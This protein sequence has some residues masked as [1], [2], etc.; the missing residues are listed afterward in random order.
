MPSSLTGT[1]L[2]PAR[3]FNVLTLTTVG[4]LVLSPSPSLAEYEEQLINDDVSGEESRI[5]PV[6]VRLDSGDFIAFWSDNSRGHT[7]VLSRRFDTSLSPLDEPTRV[8]SDEGLFSH[9][10]VAVSR[11][12]GGLFLAVWEDARTGETDRSI[13]G[14]IFDSDSGEPRTSDFRIDGTLG[15]GTDQRPR[16]HTSPD[17]ESLVVWVGLVNQKF[18]V[19]ARRIS[20][21]GSLGPDVIAAPENPTA[22]QY[23]PAVS[24]TPDGRWLLVWTEEDASH[25]RNIFF[26]FLAADGSTLGTPVRVNSDLVFQAYQDDPDVALIGSRFLLVWND[27]R[28]GP[29]D[30]WGRWV[31]F[32]GSFDGLDA[33][34]RPNQD[35]ASDQRPRIHP[36]PGGSFSISWFGGIE[37]RQRAMAQYYDS[38]GQ[39]QVEARIIDDPVSGILQRQPFVVSAGD[40]TWREFWCDNREDFW[41]CFAKPFDPASG[42]AGDRVP[43]RTN[44]RSASQMFADLDIFPDGGA[45]VAWADFRDGSV[46]I[47]A[48]FLDELGSPDGDS[49]RVGSIPANADLTT[50]DAYRSVEDYSPRVAAGANG[51]VVTWAI[52]QLGGR[53][54]FLAQYF[55]RNG[56][57]IGENFLVAP[58]DE[59]RAQRDASPVM[60]P[61]GGFAIAYQ[62]AGGPSDEG[63]SEIYLQRFAS[64]GLPIPPRIIVP[65]GAPRATKVSPSIAVAPSGTIY[66]S[67]IDDR[68]GGL[69]VM[70]QR[71][72]E[73]GQRFDTNVSQNPPDGPSS[74]Q[75][76]TD[77]AIGYDRTVSVW[78]TRPQTLGAI[79]GRLEIFATQPAAGGGEPVSSAKTGG[80]IVLLFQVN[81]GRESRGTKAPRV[82]MAQDGR[83]VVTWWENADGQTQLFAQRYEANGTKI[84]DAYPIHG[85]GSEGSRLPAQLSVDN[86]RIH[87]VWSESRREKGWDIRSRLVD[88]SFSG[89]PTPVLLR[90]AEANAELAGVELLWETALE[91]G[92]RGFH[93]HRQLSD[94]EPSRGLHP[95]AV[96]LTLDPLEAR[97]D[98]TYRYLDRS[99]PPSSRLEYFLQAIDENGQ[100][101]LFG[102]IPVATLAGTSASA[103]PNPFRDTVNLAH[104]TGDPIDIDL[105]DASGRL[106][107]TLPPSAGDDPLIWDGRDE[108]DHEV[109]TGIYFAR[110]RGGTREPIR[111]IRLK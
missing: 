36:G 5:D 49:F 3:L 72:S 109:P 106:I 58:N 37:D 76:N 64:D 108:D 51:F 18:R 59:E 61:H 8:N 52:N 97:A 23:N 54:N 105:Y 84:G 88:W 60:L 20:P 55:D 68:F 107:R 110:P 39:L 95:G 100:T 101:E 65:E 21:T 103:W 102:P 53:L 29:A 81:A 9:R 94:E 16:A 42:V 73:T 62:I 70:A 77:A 14:R 13:Y 87:Y 32:D 89:A 78:E 19:V 6:A 46:A 67:W 30:V 26:R 41:N 91:I 79:E 24:R 85:N 48:R 50:L 11:P 40:G 74:D 43:L 57:R 12:G 111:L 56:A 15:F 17:G 90:R 47:Y 82:S 1:A 35:S 75:V 27:G 80:S 31:E 10:E 63:P 66:V 71:F 99:A 44:P 4:S 28:Q 83:F 98:G 2:S 86:E 92:F 96:Q 93:I 104:S 38:S 7:D 25:D 33:T 34:F 22:Q 45:I 69:D